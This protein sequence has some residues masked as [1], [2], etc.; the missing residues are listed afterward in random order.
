M[1]VLLAIEKMQVI[2]AGGEPH[3]ALEKDGGPLHGGTVQFL[4]GQ[5]V[6][7]FRIHGIG[8]YIVSNGTTK[9]GGPVF[10]DKR[11]VVQGRI[12]GSESVFHGKHLESWNGG[13]SYLMK[14]QIKLI[15]H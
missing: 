10:G 6:T 8:V 9:A 7:D 2:Q 12:F 13:C 3:M 11:R 4:A 14:N 1:P 15:F 5:A